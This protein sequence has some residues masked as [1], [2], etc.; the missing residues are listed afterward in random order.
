MAKNTGVS[1]LDVQVTSEGPAGRKT[2]VSIEPGSSWVKLTEWSVSQ[3][4][5]SKSPIYLDLDDFLRLAAML[6]AQRRT[7]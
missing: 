3:P 2:T 4:L 1:A 7:S 6:R 5:P